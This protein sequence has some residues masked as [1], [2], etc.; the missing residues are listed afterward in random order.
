[1]TRLLRVFSLVLVSA[2]LL[3]AS[4]LAV[5]FVDTFEEPVQVSFMGIDGSVVPYDA[6]I[7]DRKS[8]TENAY[9]YGYKEY[10]NIELERIVP[11]DGTALN[12]RINTAMADGSLPDFIHVGRDMFFAMAENGVL[13]DLQPA[14]GK[15]QNKPIMEYIVNT[16]PDRIATGYYE[17]Q[18]LGI[19]VGQFYSDAEVLWVRTDWLEKVSMEVPKTFDDV[20]AVARA[21]QEAGLGGE[22]TVPLGMAGYSG[23]PSYGDITSVAAAYGVVLNTWVQGEDGIYH[24]ADTDDRMKD[25]LLKL[26]ELYKEGLIKS[27]FAVTDVLQEEVSNS[28]CGLFYGPEWFGVTCIQTNLNSDPEA[29][30]TC[31]L[32]PSLTGERVAQ[33]TKALPSDFLVATTNAEHPEALFDIAEFGMHMRYEA[34]EE[35]GLRF[36][37]CEDGYQMHNLNVTRAM[38]RPDEGLAKLQVIEAGLAEDAQ[39]VA[40]I[41]DSD[42]QQ[43]RS[44]IKDGNRETYGRYLTWMIARKS[45][46]ELGVEHPELFKTA[47]EGPVTENMT[48]YLGSINT[49]LASA[50]M[51]VV[52]GED[53]KVFEDAVATWYSAG[54]QAITDEVNAYYSGN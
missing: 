8:A 30:W 52:M 14:Y 4:A 23:S 28:S 40:A 2:L 15:V 34:S 11:E 39:S 53:I 12:A 49:A 21:F 18:W 45:I 37:V 48:L 51:K 41:A 19:P 17:G 29:D 54:G 32:L 47:Y 46:Y 27:D 10:M 42:Y 44:A 24:Y 50:M 13:Q 3:S 6:S 9:I 33:F 31:V 25:V 26:Q 35:E 5:D 36:H 16:Y 43:I 20:V 38:I 7:P 1:M 22:K